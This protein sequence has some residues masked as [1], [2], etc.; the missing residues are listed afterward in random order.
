MRENLTLN[1]NECAIA[2]AAL[3]GAKARLGGY[4]SVPGNRV[5]LL[6][7][8][9]RWKLED[10]P[11][12]V[13]RLINRLLAAVLGPEERSEDLLSLI[14]TTKAPFRLAN[15]PGKVFR[16]VGLTRTPNGPVVL[17]VREDDGTWSDFGPMDWQLLVEQLEGLE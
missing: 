6:E 16:I 8:A 3:T 10:D 15:Y 14:R 1:Y 13:D 11:G 7:D 12:A 17:E 4:Q 5:R 2:L 9:G